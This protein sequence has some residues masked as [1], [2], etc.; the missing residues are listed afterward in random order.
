MAWRGLIEHSFPSLLSWRAI[1]PPNLTVEVVLAGLT[2]V[3]SADTALRLVIV[4][5][6]LGYAFAI[7]ALI[8]AAGL[9]AYMGIPLLAFEMHYFV[10]LGFLG[11][12]WAVPLALG[13]IAVVIRQPRNPPRVPLTLLLIATWFTHIV[14]ALVAT[15]ATTTI[16][17]VAHLGNREQRPRPVARDAEGL[18]RTHRGRWRC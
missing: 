11:F 16:V 1:L 14:P 2:T 7:A 3:V 18:G 5:G 6:L 13:A 17:V 9:P 4:I 10:M 15:I 12:V 8:R